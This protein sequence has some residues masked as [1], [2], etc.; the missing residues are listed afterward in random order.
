MAE[1]LL[2]PVGLLRIYAVLD[3]FRE[4]WSDVLAP[5]Y[6]A[7]VRRNV[8][9]EGEL[10]TGGWLPTS[11][12]YEDWKERVTGQSH[13]MGIF[14]GMMY[15]NLDLGSAHVQFKAN[16]K[17]M[18]LRTTDPTALKFNSVRRLF[19]TLPELGIDGY[20]AALD[21]WLE[22][23]IGPE[24]GKER[25][26]PAFSLGTLPKQ[27]FRSGARMRRSPKKESQIYF[28]KPR[29]GKKGKE[30]SLTVTALEEARKN[31]IKQDRAKKASRLTALQ[32]AKQRYKLY[33]EVNL[34]DYAFGGSKKRK[35]KN[36]YF[37]E[38]P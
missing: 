28:G 20:R 27:D 6:M 23:K 38:E 9:E 26:E 10:V 1:P 36:W 37:D 2:R 35:K 13:R 18:E 17:S 30:R 29:V 3:D 7:D 19:P 25:I 15:A 16:R 31:L 21:T 22:F 34:D 5:K 12:Y 11:G 24:L 14:S 8:D 4:F 33:K 32:Q